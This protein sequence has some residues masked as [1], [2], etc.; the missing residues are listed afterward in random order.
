MKI[1]ENHEIFQS[2]IFTQKMMQMSD[3]QYESLELYL[4]LK[5]LEFSDEEI[6]IQMIYWVSCKDQAC[7]GTVSLYYAAW[8]QA[9]P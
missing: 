5:I 2:V 8:N 1:N 9:I 7:I 3:S 6:L 4:P